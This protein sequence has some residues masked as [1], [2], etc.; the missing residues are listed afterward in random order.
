MEFMADEHIPAP[1]MQALRDQGHLVTSA[2]TKHRA[3]RDRQLIALAAGERIVIL[4]EDEDFTARVRDT[5]AAGSELLWRCSTNGSTGWGVL[6][7]RRL[8]ASVS[9]AADRL[10]RIR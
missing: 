6:P 8:I 1:V 4:T 10:R 5:A 3:A 7:R 2:S 9:P